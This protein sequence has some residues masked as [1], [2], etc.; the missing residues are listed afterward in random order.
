M[1]VAAMPMTFDF[2]R[3]GPT[4]GAIY[5]YD[6]IVSDEEDDGITAAA[7]I[8]ALNSLEDVSSLTCYINSPGGS[9][10]A[11]WAIYNAVQRHGAAEKIAII[12]GL[13]ASSAATVA[14]A[15]PTRKMAANA[16]MMIHC[17]TDC[18]GGTSADM[19]KTADT[20]DKLND[21]IAATTAAAT[22]ATKAE[23][24]SAM[25]AET[26]YTAKE[27]LDFGLITEIIAPNLAQAVARVDPKNMGR[28]N[29]RHPEK[30]TAITGTA[31]K[32]PAAVAAQNGD[33]SMSTKPKPP[34]EPIKPTGEPAPAAPETTPPAGDPQNAAGG[35]P[36]A[37]TP[38]S[39]QNAADG[40]KFLDAFGDQGG[41]WYAKGMSFADA[42]NAYTAGLKA[43]NSALKSENADLKTRLAVA[44]KAMGTDPVSAADGEPKNIDAAT[45]KAAKKLESLRRT[46]KGDEQRAQ[47]AFSEWKKQEARKAAK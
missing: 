35:Q 34:A 42:Q 41:V 31:A 11:A 13:A 27:A 29:F 4:S 16:M 9:I 47:N 25:E 38:A 7:F 6:L 30:L 8:A 43:E 28:L 24:F 1:D 15:F 37:A 10:Y 26:W 46:F 21:T 33:T 5:L 17:A 2:R 32:H 3:T 22:G 40:K 14:L 39:P 44:T 12:D 18:C 23:V 20:L 19:R 36:A 45:E